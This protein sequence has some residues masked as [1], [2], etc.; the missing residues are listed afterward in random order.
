MTLSLQECVLL[1]ILFYQNGDSVTKSRSLKRLRKYPLTSQG[2]TNMI[3]TF[4]AMGTLVI[5]PG[6]GR[7][8]VASQAA[9]DVATQV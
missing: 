9:N 8:C 5:K 3:R 6:R 4:E 7:K 1:V 2:V